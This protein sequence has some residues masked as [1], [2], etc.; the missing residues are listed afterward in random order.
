MLSEKT[1][2]DFIDLFTGLDRAYGIYHLPTEA[3]MEGTKAKGHG[4][5]HAGAVTKDLYEQHLRGEICLGITPIMDGDIC[6]FGAID[7]D[8]YDGL[9]HKGVAKKI[10][11]YGMP[12]IPCMTKSQG[13]HLYCF[14]TEPIPAKL[15]RDKLKIFSAYLG[16]GD[17]EIFPK[18]DNIL[19]DKGD[20]GNWIN[21]P[22]WDRLDTDRYA[23]DETGKKYTIEE[24]IEVARGLRWY[25]KQFAAFNVLQ[26]LILEDAPPCVETLLNA[27]IH[28]GGRNKGLFGVSLYLRRKYGENWVAQLENINREYCHPP[29]DTREVEGVYKSVCKGDYGYPCKSDPFTGL[30]N[31]VLCKQRT[32]GVRDRDS[33]MLK[34]LTKYAST[35]PIWFV[36]LEGLGRLEV[37]DSSL[38]INQTL[39]IQLC[40][41]QYNVLP[42]PFKKDDWSEIIRNLLEEVA[43]I[44]I[45]SDA[46]DYGVFDD[47]FQKFCM[48]RMQGNVIEDCV[49]NKP[50][51]DKEGVYFRFVSLFNFL[52][53]NK[54]K[55]FQI[56]KLAQQLKQRGCTQEEMDLSGRKV[57]IW[58]APISLFETG[59]KLPVPSVKENTVF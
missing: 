17:S 5:T 50:Y 19:S 51:R 49:T 13:L 28:D 23:I 48:G 54:F 25:P 36:D 59:D 8:V 45:P 37:G 40:M 2:N 12:L 32:F 57:S 4:T 11:E 53:R 56:N 15:M 44:N 35:P 16:F 27:G 26:K 24:M 14:T 46:S 31:R 7:I 33:V 43:V 9:D 38:L 22:Y 10:K 21:L 3:M 1:L 39:F 30:C 6:Q 18:Q 34:N 42:K 20:C 41:N 47:L 58:K 52:E 55:S 29:L